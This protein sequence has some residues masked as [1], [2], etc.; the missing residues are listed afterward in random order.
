MS[1]PSLASQAPPTARGRLPHSYTERLELV[2]EITR[3]LAAEIHLDNLLLLI[4]HKTCEA[5]SAD[6]CTVYVVD[7]RRQELMMKVAS[8]LEIATTR[9]PLGRGLAGYVAQTGQTL[10]IPDCYADPRFDRSW[11]QRTGYRTRTMLV[12]AMRNSRQQIIGVFQVINK[13]PPKGL[14]GGANESAALAAPPVFTAE[15]EE[16]LASIAASAAIAVENAQLYE[17]QRAAYDSMVNTL[18]STIDARD[19]QTAGHSHRVAL[20]ATILARRLGLPSE[21]VELIRYAG[22]L[23]D[24]GKIGVPDAV[25]TKPGQL[26]E[27]ERRLMNNHAAL[28]RTIL[29]NMQFPAGLEEVPRIAAQHHERLDGTGYPDGITGQELTL[30]GRLLAVADLYD[31]LRTRRYYKPAFSTEKSLEIIRSVAGAHVDPAVVAVLEA[32]L[33]EIEAAVSALRP[34]EEGAPPSD[35]RA[36]KANR[37]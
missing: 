14:P 29:S 24:Y 23:H 21:Q 1:A 28:T 31:A 2:L 26:T 12:M 17:Q 5:L 9:L 27:E 10:N 13:L 30:A 25:L 19:P 7:R 15:D 36:E 18:A 37:P 16:L 11:D 33:P 8:E 22:L 20:T 3:L 4:S 6:R 35:G 32:A 34:A